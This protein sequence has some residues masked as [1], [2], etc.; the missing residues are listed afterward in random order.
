[1]G[2]LENWFIL[3]A[4]FLMGQIDTVATRAAACI[5]EARARGDRYTESTS[6]AYIM[7]LVWLAIDRPTDARDEARQAISLWADPNWH[8]QHWAELRAQCC[9]DLYEGQGARA[10]QRLEETRRRM[11]ESL[12]LRVRTPRLEH[13]HLE[14]R[15]LLEA[16]W[17]TKSPATLLRKAA[18]LADQLEAEH[19]RFAAAYACSLRAGLAARGQG[20]AAAREAFGLAER[21]FD[22]L[23][24]P[25]HTAAARRRQG[26]LLGGDGGTKLIDESDAKLAELGVRAPERFARFLV[27]RAV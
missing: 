6:R 20:G 26:E 13:H 5:A 22:A 23:N 18:A 25:L 10:A 17:E 2:S 11:K 3:H 16:A 27:P 7:P 1:M 21:T 8:H 19:N 15:G 24:M 12:V 9:A 14:A 4:R